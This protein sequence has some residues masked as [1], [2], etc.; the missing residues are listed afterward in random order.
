MGSAWGTWALIM[1]VAIPLAVS[2]QISLPLVIG[3]VLAGGSL[4]DNAS[5]LGETAI[6]S[7]TIADI[8]LMEHVKS[9]LPYSLSGVILSL[10]AFLLFGLIV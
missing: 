5:P 2:A 8:P 10:A 3:S 9:Q 1:P 6:L 4:G 7:S